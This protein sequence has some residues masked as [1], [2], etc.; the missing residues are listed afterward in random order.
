MRQERIAVLGGDRREAEAAVTLA[1]RGLAVTTFGVAWIRRSPLDRPSLLEA[2]EGADAVVGPALGCLDQ[3]LYRQSPTP[4]LAI[5]PEAFARTRPGAPW[6]I[7]RARS[8]LR[9]ACDRAGAPLLEYGG[10]DAYQ[11]ANAIPTAE[12]AI[13]EGSRLGGRTAWGSVALVVGSGRCGQAIAHRLHALG[14]R[15][16]VAARRH[17]DPEPGIGRA[18]LEDIPAFARQCDLLFNTVPAPIIT[19]RTLA[20]TPRRVVIV[21]IATAPGGVDFAAAE[22]LDR[23]AVLLPGIPGRCFP[24]TAGRIVAETVL[25]ALGWTANGPKEGV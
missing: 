19:Q 10:L 1:E 8:W 6:C 23:T 12:G 11:R 14:A 22:A 9:E 16:T 25:S 2:L 24:L 20:E 21:D 17:P 4:P 13:A 3:G 18:G 5:P 15:V 7:G